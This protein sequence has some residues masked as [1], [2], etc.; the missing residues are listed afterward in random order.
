MAAAQGL[1]AY[2]TTGHD[3]KYDSPIQRQA[4]SPANRNA[5]PWS[6]VRKRRLLQ[7]LV[8]VLAVYFFIKYLPTDLPT[9]GQRI[10]SRTGRRQ[11]PA[12]PVDFTASRD[13]LDKS[14]LYDGQIRFYNL[15]MSL[16]PH[17]H[18]NYGD[19]RSLVFLLRDLRTAG[20]L[21]P[22]ACQMGNFNRTVV[23]LAVISPQDTKIPDIISLIGID[24]AD[25]PVY[26]HDARP[27]FNGQSSAA[28]RA[29]SIQSAMDHL[30]SSLQASAF[31]VDNAQISDSRYKTIVQEK[32]ASLWTSLIVVPQDSV[33][34]VNWITS[35]DGSSFSALNSV[36]IDI[37]IS[38]YQNSAG[39]LLRLLESIRNANYGGVPRPRITVE[40]PQN[41]DKFLLRYLED[42]RWPADTSL[43]SSYLIL[44]RRFDSNLLNPTSASVQTIESFYPSSTS[45]AHL[46]VLSPDVELSGEY[47]QYLMYT[48]LEYKHGKVGQQVSAS[49]MGI[50]LD[51]PR[52]FSDLARSPNNLVGSQTPSSTAALY[53]G[54]RW[55]ELQEYTI[56]RL[57]R[58][59]TLSKS[60]PGHA[61]TSAKQPTWQHLASEFMTARNYVMLYPAFA[62]DQTSSLVTVHQEFHQDPEEYAKLIETES[63]KT[64]VKLV[65]PLSDDTV[66]VADEEQTQT[67]AHLGRKQMSKPTKSLRSLMGL[68]GYESLPPG[69]TLPFIAPNGKFMELVDVQRISHT[70][71]NELSLSVGGCRSLE[72]RDKTKFGSV[73]YLFCSYDGVD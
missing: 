59:P 71:A 28:R 30:R 17:T 67:H 4:W 69:T 41:V 18:A 35:L 32:S 72:D 22:L 2:Y 34:S 12:L 56:S 16:R 5:R 48:L 62:K 11:G 13:K 21:V 36:K 27:D 26:W 10:D 3:K 63:K 37:V 52:K 9:V 7:L 23:H 6:M 60:V 50:S 49:L 25:C 29:R 33:T 15:A 31:V 58:D 55:T 64:P 47:F 19:K 73:A 57:K 1:A 46:L 65:P 45:S 68:E 61:K 8:V 54:D 24:S 39:S 66:L 43:D 14:Q 38:A 42:F 51:L 70:F 40:L 20:S 53:F 44:R